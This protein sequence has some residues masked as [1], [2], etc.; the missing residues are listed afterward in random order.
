MERKQRRRSGIIDRLEPKPC[1][2]VEKML[3]NG[4]TPTARLLSI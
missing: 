1:D 3:S 4:A 2:N